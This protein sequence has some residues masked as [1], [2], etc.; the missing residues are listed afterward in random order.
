[1]LPHSLDTPGHG[2]VTDELDRF[3]RP[4]LVNGAA[5]LVVASDERTYSVLGFTVVDG[6]S[7]R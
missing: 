5:G 2:D 4:A 3:S 7:S 1:L 6:K